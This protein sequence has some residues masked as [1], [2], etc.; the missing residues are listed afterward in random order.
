MSPFEVVQ[1]LRSKTLRN[2]VGLWLIPLKLLGQERDQAAL[3]SIGHIDIREYLLTSLP[4]DTRFSGLNGDRLIELLDEICARKHG[5]DCLLIY[6]FDLLISRLAHADRQKLWEQ[7][8]D[9]FPH[10]RRSLLITMPDQAANLL[11]PIEILQVWQQENRL[12][13]QI[14]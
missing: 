12:A 9:G 13:G 6:H 14:L 1:L 10:R 8:Y 11:P 3:L 5:M 7:L 4:K 2:S